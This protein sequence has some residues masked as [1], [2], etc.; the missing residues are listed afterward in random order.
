[1]HGIWEFDYVD[2]LIVVFL[3]IIV[4]EILM[5]FVR[6]AN[7]FREE[8]VQIPKHYADKIKFEFIEEK[9]EKYK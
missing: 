4:W 1:V 3:A 8:M 9:K 6:W 5:R 7:P 2:R